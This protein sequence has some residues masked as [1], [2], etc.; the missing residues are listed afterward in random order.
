MWLEMDTTLKYLQKLEVAELLHV[1]A[2]RVAHD[3]HPDAPV[4]K[5]TWFRDPTNQNGPRFAIAPSLLLRKLLWRD[6]IYIVEAL[7]EFYQRYPCKEI[8]FLIHD[9]KRGALGSGTVWAG[10]ERS[11]NQAGA[12]NDHTATS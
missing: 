6:V 1:V 10:G 3:Y 2:I 7:K 9:T 12:E 4:A 5:R 11:D 8:A